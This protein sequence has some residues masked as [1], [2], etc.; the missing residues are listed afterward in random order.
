MHEGLGEFVMHPVGGGDQSEGAAEHSSVDQRVGVET[1]HHWPQL[2][3]QRHFGGDHLEEV[4]PKASYFN[5]FISIA[6]HFW[7]QQF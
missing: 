6:A 2:L 7:N 5:L 4:L 3:V 1:K